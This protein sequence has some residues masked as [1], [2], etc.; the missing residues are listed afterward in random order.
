MNYSERLKKRYEFEQ[1]ADK[2]MEIYIKIADDLYSKHK[3]KYSMTINMEVDENGIMYEYYIDGYDYTAG[4]DH[5]Y[6]SVEKLESLV[7]EYKRKERKNKLNKLK[8]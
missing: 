2:V 5:F 7:E 8:S 1:Q 6:V 3:S 4:R